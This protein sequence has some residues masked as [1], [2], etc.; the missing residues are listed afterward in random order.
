MRTDRV[1]G[2]VIFI[3]SIHFWYHFGN[4]L[5]AGRR[6][7]RA[8]SRW[9]KFHATRNRFLEKPIFIFKNFSPAVCAIIFKVCCFGFSSNVWTVQV[10]WNISIHTVM[11][12]CDLFRNPKLIIICGPGKLLVE[13]TNIYGLWSLLYPN[14]KYEQCWI[15]QFHLY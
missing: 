3:L 8:F 9:Q 14:T 2:V 10:C 12:K 11:L 7:D 6:P 1:H 15:I 5:R 13:E 4:Q